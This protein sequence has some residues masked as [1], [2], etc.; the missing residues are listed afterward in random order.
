MTENWTPHLT[1]VQEGGVF[2]GAGW[3]VACLWEA[4]GG[5]KERVWAV[6]AG[7][8]ESERRREGERARD[9]LL[10]SVA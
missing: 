10:G 6:W 3:W 9:G 1:G 7:E 2:G 8:S 5:M 4:E